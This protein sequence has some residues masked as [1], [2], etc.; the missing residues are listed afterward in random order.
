[1]DSS[2][3]KLAV[4]RRASGLKRKTKPRFPTIAD[5]PSILPNAG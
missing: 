5:V 3:V 1:M 2:S 4:N